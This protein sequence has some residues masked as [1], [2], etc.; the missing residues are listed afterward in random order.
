[1]WIILKYFLLQFFN[2]WKH[3][4]LRI[5]IEIVILLTVF[6]IYVTNRLVIQFRSFLEQS[7][8]TALHLNMLIQLLLLLP[9]L[10]GIPF[11]YF[12]LIPRQKSI[13]LLRSLPLG[14]G[15]SAMLLVVYF[16]KY[17]L[18]YL[19]IILPV[20]TAVGITLGWW[21]LSYLLI[22]LCLLP[23]VMNLFLHLL[24]TIFSSIYKVLFI[25][26]LLVILCYLFLMGLYLTPYYLFYQIA[27]YILLT[28]FVY[29][30]WINHW[31]KWDIILDRFRRSSA[32]KKQMIP[33]GTINYFTLA[34]YVP[35]AI[36]PV[37]IK[38]ILLQIRN[39]RYLRLKV[40]TLIFFLLG[41][42][43][44]QQYAAGNFRTLLAFLVIV[45]IW[46]H[47]S[48]QFNEK[49][50]L[51]ESKYF[52]KTMPLRYYQFVLPKFLAELIY[53][54]ILTCLVFIIF[55]WHG[56]GLPAASMSV[57]SM[58]IVAMFILLTTIIFKTM[59]Y[60]NPR[61]AGYAYHF[62]ILFCLVISVNFYFIG[63]VITIS[64]LIYYS[65][66][67]YQAFSQ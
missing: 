45:L 18:I 38:E 48:S 1:M 56:E 65:Y 67:S 66:K 10:T 12:S 28:L 21:P 46:W 31:E 60:D 42:L 22:L 39:H 8:I 32:G 3:L 47:Y 40:L 15:Q 53:I 37:F 29:R 59:F 63:P 34:D 51:P 19:I 20:A 57:L 54:M 14:S 52:L 43:L 23:S 5:K 17:A 44:I 64:L 55:L 26:L 11:I 35:L 41:A 13:Q 27:I 49:Y 30:F 24:S 7:D 61:L 58:F 9:L 16:W 6:F 62:L 4:Q 2:Y 36:R 50:V 33:F 25:Y